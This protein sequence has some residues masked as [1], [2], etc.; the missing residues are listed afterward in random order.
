MRRALFALGVGRAVGESISAATLVA[1]QGVAPRLARLAHLWLSALAR[2]GDLTADGLCF[3]VRRPFADAPPAPL[4]GGP[5]AE[6]LSRFAEAHVDVLT[7]RR[8]AR[9]VAFPEGDLVA[10]RRFYAESLLSRAGSGVGARI[11]EALAADRAAPL[12]VLEVGAGTGGFTSAFLAGVAGALVDYLFTDTSP[13]FLDAARARF[14]DHPG[15]RFGVFDMEADPASQGLQPGAFDLVIGA[16][17]FHYSTD[18]EALL[19]RLRGLLAPGGVLLLVDAF[20]ARPSMLASMMMLDEGERHAVDTPFLISAEEWC[21]LAHAAGFAEVESVEFADPAAQRIGALVVVARTRTGATVIDREAVRGFLGERLPTYMVPEQLLVLSALPLSANGK[22]DRARLPAPEQVKTE[23]A[24]VA[25]RT[26]TERALVEVWRAH[27]G[28]PVGVEDD[29]FEAGGDSLSAVQL[30]GRIR[31]KLGVALPLRTLFAAP[32]IARLAPHCEGAEAATPVEQAAI[33]ADPEN[34]HAPFPLT[35]IQHAYWFGRLGGLELGGVGCQIYV[36]FEGAGWSVERLQDAVRR[37]IARHEMLRAVVDANGQQRVLAEVPDYVVEVD[38]LRGLAT[39]AVEARLSA[40]RE[41]M[42]WQTRDPAVWPLF[43][44]RASRLPGDVVRLH[45]LFDALIADGNSL[46]LIFQQFDTLFGDPDAPAA[47]LGVTFRDYVLALPAARAS[48][49]WRLAEAYWMARLDALPPAP[50]LPLAMD[51]NRLTAPR[52]HRREAQL[53]AAQWQRLRARASAAQ[54]TPSGVLLTA[55][56]T[57]LA[58]WSRSPHFCLNLTL[59]N[60]PLLHPDL[61]RVVGDFTTLTLLEVD[62]RPGEAFA[63]VARRLQDRLWADLDHRA[64]GGVEVLRRMA[65]RRGAGLGARMPVVFTSMLGVLEHGMTLPQLGPPIF[66]VSQTPQVWLDQQVWVLSDGLTLSW[67]ALDPLFPPG[68]LDAMFAAYVDVVRRLADDEAAWSRPLLPK[69]PAAQL[70][71]REAI[72]ATGTPVVSPALHGAAF[73]QAAARPG[74]LAV[75]TA[76][77]SLDH[78]TLLGAAHAVGVRLRAAGARAGE[79]V[80]VVAHKGVEQIIALLAVLDAGAP[81]VPIDAALP[82]SR[83]AHLLAHAGVRIAVT[84]PEVDAA[85]DWPPAVRRVVV[86]AADRAALA[87]PS[88]ASQPAPDELAYVIYTSGSTG[89]P[90]GVM[91][92]HGGAVNTLVAVNAAFEVGP[93]D[94]VLALSSASF[95]LSVYDVFGVLGAG[96]AVVLPDADRNRDPAHWA[97]LMRQHGVTIWNTVPAL[98]EMLVTWAERAD[99]E[100]LRG[101]RVILLSGDWIPVSLPDRIRALA[102]E[103]RIVSLGG[104][105]EGSVWS[106]WHPIERVDPAWDS[107]PYGRPMPGQRFYVL[108]EALQPRP[109]D[110]PGELFIGGRG[111]ALGYWGD[112]DQTAARFV[113]HPVTGERLYRTGDLGRWRGDVIEFLGRVDFQVKI[114]GHRVELGEVESA[115]LR[116]PSVGGAVAVAAGDPRGE[117]TLVA[118]VVPDARPATLPE[119]GLPEAGEGL[120]LDPLARVD[121]KLA[122]HGLRRELDAEPGQ[123]LPAPPSTAELAERWRARRSERRF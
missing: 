26:P 5:I 87:P 36:E 59:F 8:D 73:A 67:D 54:L 9:G 116:Q 42:A 95:D 37:L 80:A 41:A 7:G 13:R 104:A 70:A 99:R 100:A 111:V 33:V 121:F 74:A 68:L 78:T 2:A 12:R 91:I 20:P 55:F 81:Y 32:T 23:R 72:N 47:P 19:T 117:R 71:M 122:H 110:V 76:D 97:A 6:T 21:A 63:T 105:T 112:A 62:G 103:A 48:E 53:P 44:V 34:R 84:T 93:R 25:P 83:V 85:L 17:V 38:D 65:Q 79:L 94:R 1:E 11:V 28:R 43:E 123:A 86:E 29:F 113:T 39:E 46:F 58:R 108:D 69:L 96:G 66:G 92:D 101:L 98:M 118:Y 56:A 119:G 115:L 102:P 10:A 18:P 120:I 24:H 30:V 114:G 50:Q 52:F 49:A 90:K 35:D 60:R 89:Q 22:V 57:T 75:A 16:A 88:S 51:P 109:D 107:I 106:I 4:V 61:A 15:V 27:L 64:F 3:T 31:E 77:R 82:A 14:A 45:C 40:R